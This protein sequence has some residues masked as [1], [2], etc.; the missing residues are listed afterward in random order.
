[1]A[2]K[3]QTTMIILLIVLVVCGGICWWIKQNPKAVQPS[4]E[5]FHNVG[6][7]SPTYDLVEN[8]PREVELET[9]QHETDL[10]GF[11]MGPGLVD[12]RRHNVI[13]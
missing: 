1:M 5:E 4:A 7:G 10:Q 13:A 9:L 8:D 3:N 11:G 12:S 2:R 6:S